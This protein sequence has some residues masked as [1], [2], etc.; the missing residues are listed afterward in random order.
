MLSD[1]ALAVI[2]AVLQLL[3]VGL[4]LYVTLVPLAKEERRRR[5]LCVIVFCV[6]GLAGVVVVGVIARRAG[7]V[8]RNVTEIKGTV[9]EIQE[10]QTKSLALA[11]EPVFHV[12]IR[13]LTFLPLQLT[14]DPEKQ[15]SCVLVDAAVVN[16][17]AP[18]EVQAFQLGARFEGSD[19]VTWGRP[20]VMPQKVG[21]Q[22]SDGTSVYYAATSRLDVKA[23]SKP[24]PTRGSV[25]GVMLFSFPDIPFESLTSPA[26]AYELTAFDLSGKPYRGR[27]KGDKSVDSMSELRWFPGVEMEVTPGAKAQDR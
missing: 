21:G 7:N 18:S 13:Q 26:T 22:L 12:R 2:A 24:I 27:F 23:R 6:V 9:G 5:R 11:T 20:Q 8:P 3:L 1:A 17:G 10:Q 4:G 16:T 25:D 15:V 19:A 14:V